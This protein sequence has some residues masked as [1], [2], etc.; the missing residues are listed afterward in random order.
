[1]SSATGTTVASRAIA[2]SLFSNSPP[3]SMDMP[4]G[5][6]AS[7]SSLALASLTKP[8]MSRPRT[9]IRMPM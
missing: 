5:S 1:M 9:F 4:V 7:R 8:P 3:H 2:R 6:G